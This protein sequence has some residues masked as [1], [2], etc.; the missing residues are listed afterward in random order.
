[1]GERP[2]YKAGDGIAGK[3][4]LAY[5]RYAIAGFNGI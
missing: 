1:M 5:T 3:L 4:A 2:Q